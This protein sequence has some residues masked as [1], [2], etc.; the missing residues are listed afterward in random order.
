[1]ESS[2][3][4]RG[5]CATT[6]CLRQL[7][8]LAVDGAESLKSFAS[9]VAHEMRTPIGQI[10]S[11]AAMLLDQAAPLSDAEARRWI[12]LQLRIAKQMDSTVQGLLELAKVSACGTLP[13]DIDVSAECAELCETLQ[14]DVPVLWDIEPRMRIH[15]Y[16]PLV[17]VVLRNLLGNAAKYSQLTPAPRVEVSL[18]RVGVRRFVRVR[19]NGAGFDMAAATRLFQPFSRL[20]DPAQ[21]GGVGLGLCIVKR[22]IDFHGGCIAARSAPGAGACFEFSL[23]S[24]AADG[25]PAAAA[26]QS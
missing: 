6:P 17:K 14:S 9:D 2:F 3:G 18:Q 22:I 7:N 11:I 12:G 26:V 1:M 25:Q 15:G 8:H 5:G 16:K 10:Q 13:E 20:H 24:A 4:L 23:E 19:D 21:F